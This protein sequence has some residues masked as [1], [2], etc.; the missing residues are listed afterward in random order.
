MDLGFWVFLGA[1]SSACLSN[2]QPQI[3]CWYL[4][5]SNLEVGLIYIFAGVFFYI[6]WLA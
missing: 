5:D 2:M 3:F 6:Q 4:L 1:V